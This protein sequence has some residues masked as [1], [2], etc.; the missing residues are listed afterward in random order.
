[1]GRMSD[2]KTDAIRQYSELG[3]DDLIKLLADMTDS[4]PADVAAVILAL[5]NRREASVPARR[6]IGE[7]LRHQ[8]IV[9][10]QYRQ[11]TAEGVS[12][13][14]RRHATAPKE[15]V[16]EIRA[17]EYAGTAM[18]RLDDLKLVVE[19]IVRDSEHEFYMRQ[20]TLLNGLD[21]HK[22]PER[23]AALLPCI[24]QGHLAKYSNSGDYHG[25]KGCTCA[26]P[27]GRTVN[28]L[29][30]RDFIGTRRGLGYNPT[31]TLMLIRP[32]SS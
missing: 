18:L 26:R 15:V 2:N 16:D 12:D 25:K 6:R 9:E 8:G 28:A 31:Y 20:A 13:Y 11:D 30:K 32:K 21:T 5:K 17:D 10:Q 7:Y 14:T 3:E 24:A 27:D 22:L 29:V 4:V 23:Q 1:M 19:P